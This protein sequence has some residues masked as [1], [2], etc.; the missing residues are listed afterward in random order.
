MGPVGPVGP[1]GA[2]GERGAI[3]PRGRSGSGSVR[4]YERV[5]DSRGSAW[6]ILPRSDTPPLFECFVSS[7]SQNQNN[8][9]IAVVWIPTAFF[10]L[11][12]ALLQMKD[13]SW[14]IELI[15]AGPGNYALFV[16]YG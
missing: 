10:G 7:K 14:V 3:G 6:V 12:C 8:A 5:V 4:A 1:M 13:G 15:D 16:V 9:D 11:S 2:P